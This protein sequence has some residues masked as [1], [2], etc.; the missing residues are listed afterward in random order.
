MIV[1]LLTAWFCCFALTVNAAMPKGEY[2]DGK[3]SKVGV[4]L[5]HGSG[6]GADSNVVGP[7]RREIHAQLGFHTLSLE[8]PRPESGQP[9]DP[10]TFPEAYENI[11]AGI[12]FLKKEKKVERIYLMG[13]SMGG[14][15]TSGFIA[16]HADHGVTGFIGVGLLGGGKEPFNTNVNLRK[17]AIPVLD[18]YAPNDAADAKFAAVRKALVSDNYRQVGLSG[19]AHSFKGYGSNISSVIRSWLTEQE[20]KAVTR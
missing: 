5:A 8:M 6:G 2:L 12:D 20:A 1:R 7:L 15:T 18:V 4:I 19:A 11:R 17:V 16:N 13:Y 10:S 9:I 14:R 3:D